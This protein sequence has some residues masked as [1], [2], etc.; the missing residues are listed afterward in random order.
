M[1]IRSAGTRNVI[2]AMH[3]H[4]VRKLAVQT[5]FGVGETRHKLPF[6]YRLFFKLVLKP[7][8]ADMEHQEQMVRASGLDRVIAQPV[9]LTD[10]PDMAETT[11]R[12]LSRHFLSGSRP[13]FSG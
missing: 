10:R 1:D 5:S 7:Q 12:P 4:G 13:I 9:N 11:G 3:R 6:A 2:A 8:I